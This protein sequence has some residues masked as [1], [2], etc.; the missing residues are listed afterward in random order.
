M[1]SFRLSKIL[2]NTI[3]Y[4]ILTAFALV[5]LFPFLYMFATSLKTPNDT[6]TYPP[7][8]FPREQS[9]IELDG[10]DEPSPLYYVLANGEKKEYAL[11]QS[12]VPAGVYADPND[13]ET[14]YAVPL[15]FVKPAIGGGEVTLPDAAVTVD[16]LYWV[17]WNDVSPNG[18]ALIDLFL[19]PD[20]NRN[21]GNQISLLGGIS[22]QETTNAAK[23]N[24]SSATPGTYYV[25]AAINMT[26][27][28]EDAYV[29]YSPQRITIDFAGRFSK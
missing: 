9:T 14:A 6:F 16:S 20:T 27:T 23:L 29:D 28:P 12:G 3:T 26:A 18:N 25:G 4:I 7:R 15:A 21:N 22:S 2:V 11:V 1:N 17:T 8:L 10:Y 13:L 19:D 5:M 24:L